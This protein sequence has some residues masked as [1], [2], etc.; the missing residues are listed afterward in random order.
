MRRTT[1]ALV[2]LVSLAAASAEAK[3]PAY[4]PGDRV[5]VTAQRAAIKHGQKVVGYLVRG[6][7]VKILLVQG[8]F[9][10]VNFQA[11]DATVKDGYVSLLDLE[12]PARKPK[13][14]EV[15]PYKPGDDVIVVAK[16]ATLK[17][18]KTVLGHVAIGTRLAVK[19]V[20]GTW[21]G[22]W[23]TLGDKRVWGYMDHHDVDYAPLSTRSA[24]DKT[25]PKPKAP[26]K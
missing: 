14:A 20:Q 9:A 19:K 16:K 24:P 5:A 12:R 1:A 11:D 25:K 21:I 26:A 6:Q 23:A 15:A 18:G 22:V 13:P 2:L 8:N 17:K 3:D 10:R 4:K 7:R